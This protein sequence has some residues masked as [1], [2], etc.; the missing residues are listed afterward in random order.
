V[1]GDS[2]G[3]IF[4]IK[5]HS[6]T[7]HTKHIGIHQD[8]MRD[9]YQNGDLDYE[10]IKGMDNPADIFTKALPLPAFSKHRLGI[11]MVELPLV[12]R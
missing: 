11:G 3:G 1:R 5:N 7:R 12:L 10:H 8:F 6:Y 4:A 2:A 9:R